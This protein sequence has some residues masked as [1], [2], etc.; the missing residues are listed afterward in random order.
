MI[1]RRTQTFAA[2]GALALLLAAVPNANA[3][4]TLNLEFAGKDNGTPNLTVSLNGS[5]MTVTPAPYFFNSSPP[6]SGGGSPI[7]SFCIQ[8]TAGLDSTSYAP[9]NVVSLTDPSTT[10]SANNGSKATQVANAIE[11]LYGMYYNTAWGTQGTGST[12]SAAF[13]L[14]LWELTYDGAA[15][16]TNTNNPNF[17][18]SGSFQATWSSSATE[19]QTMLNQVLNNVSQGITDFNN[20]LPGETLVALTNPSLQDQL[21]LEPTPKVPVN[22]VPAPSGLL[23]AGFGLVALVGRSR[24]NRRTPATA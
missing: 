8:L 14:A 1:A 22:G 6:P 11:A 10:I 20:N 5:S 16:V 23:L 18:G 3:D 12:A 19:A 2:A 4:T 15:D 21:W 7:S 9:Y 13:Q 17:L 24:L